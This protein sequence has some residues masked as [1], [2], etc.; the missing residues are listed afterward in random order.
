MFDRTLRPPGGW[1][2]ATSGD[3]RGS[4]APPER[5]SLVLFKCLTGEI[6]RADPTAHLRDTAGQKNFQS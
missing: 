3:P 5:L 6:W 1:A 4:P 2:A